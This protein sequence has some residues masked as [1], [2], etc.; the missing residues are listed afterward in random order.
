MAK[1]IDSKQLDKQV[2]TIL[3][4][5][6]PETNL[7]E[8]SVNI[9]PI[10]KIDKLLNEFSLNY[11]SIDT[12]LKNNSNDFFVYKPLKLC[13]IINKT[14]KQKLDLNSAY[15]SIIYVFTF[16][17]F[18]SKLYSH[19]RNVINSLEQLEIMHLDPGNILTLIVRR[20]NLYCF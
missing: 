14:N 4:K 1:Q 16:E 6:V 11:D 3:V 20:I 15:F 8:E 17:H 5:T 12:F 2:E 18:N 7:K 10:T 13:E 9:S 19:C